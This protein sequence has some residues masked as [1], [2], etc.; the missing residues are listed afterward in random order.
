MRLGILGQLPDTTE[1]IE[2]MAKAMKP[3]GLDEVV[4]LGAQDRERRFLNRFIPDPYERLVKE[5]GWMPVTQE[6]TQV[7]APQDFP[8]V[9][10]MCATPL[11]HD[12]AKKTTKMYTKRKKILFSRGASNSR[13]QRIYRSPNANAMRSSEPLSFELYDIQSGKRPRA[14]NLPLLYAHAVN[15]GTHHLAV[16]ETGS[17]PAL[18]LFSMHALLHR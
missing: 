13:V 15:V 14:L 4:F 5:Q 2:H 1:K 16:Y 8:H 18:K 12:Y 7:Y 10:I 11:Q 17:C 9:L 6:T 3:L